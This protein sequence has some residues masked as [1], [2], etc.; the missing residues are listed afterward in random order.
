MLIYRSL[1]IIYCQ[2][3][4][5][6]KYHL[7]EGLNFQL[8]PLPEAEVSPNLHLFAAG[9]PIHRLTD[10]FPT[11]FASLKP[12][13]QLNLNIFATVGTL[14][15]R[16]WNHL[17]RSAVQVQRQQ[18]R[19][20]SF[21]SRLSNWERNDGGAQCTWSW[22]IWFI[23]LPMN[24]IIL[25]A[26]MPTTQY[27]SQ[28]TWTNQNWCWKKSFWLRFRTRCLRPLCLSYPSPFRHCWRFE[29]KFLI[30]TFIWP[31]KEDF[32]EFCNFFMHALI[33]PHHVF[34]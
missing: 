28:C 29:K 23:Q 4:Y 30:S 13:F 22:C 1:F 26:P 27:T 3:L 25:I 34:K 16:K 31:V 32:K 10:T 8:P 33:N 12:N 19:I 2:Y 20:T 11:I 18:N 5:N 7:E 17:Y 9:R 21:E 6:F 15:R 24:W 14:M